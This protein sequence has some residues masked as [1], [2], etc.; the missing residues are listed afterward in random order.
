MTTTPGQALRAAMDAFTEKQEAA[1]PAF[2]A[3][4]DESIEFKD[5]LVHTHG[6][7]AFGDAMRKL[8]VFASR[9]SVDCGDL[10]ESQ[11]TLFLAWKLTL[12]TRVGPTVTLPGVTH[13]RTH[14][15]KI[16]WQRDHWDLASALA[17]AFP[18]GGAIYRR[19]TSFFA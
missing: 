5:P 4:Y 6:R 19:L 12:V 11:D 16:T 1:L 14:D 7:E 10:V 2:L 9:L 15:G 8:F 17:H 18:G 3:L 13:A